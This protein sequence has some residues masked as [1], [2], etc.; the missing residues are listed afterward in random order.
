MRVISGKARGTRLATIE[1]VNTR[2]TTDRVKESLFNLIQFYVHDAVVVDLFAGSGALGIE[3]ASRGAESV[4][5]VEQHRKCHEAIAYNISKTGL[6]NVTLIKGD[7][8]ASMSRLPKTDLVIMDPP[9]S[10]DMVIPVI[11]R[12]SELDVLSKEGV[13]VVE[14]SKDDMLPQAIKNF[15]MIKSKKYGITMISIYEKTEI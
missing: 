5:L 12:L 10:Q 8:M 9:Y 2:P 3:A 14:H 6:D 1:G 7:V 11:E 13:I 4:V 15:E